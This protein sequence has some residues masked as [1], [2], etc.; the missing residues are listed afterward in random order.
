[1]VSAAT[2]F[3]PGVLLALWLAAPRPALAQDTGEQ[4]L[5]NCEHLLRDMKENGSTVEFSTAPDVSI[6]WGFMRAIQDLSA[7]IKPDGKRLLNIC[8]P[9]DGGL[10]QMIRVV[11]NYGEQHPDELDERPGIFALTALQKAFPCQ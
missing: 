8:T 5:S 11:V 1:M 9:P 4:L 6:C 7:L 10:T 2:R 3:V